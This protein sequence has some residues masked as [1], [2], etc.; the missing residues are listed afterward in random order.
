VRFKFC[1]GLLQ[2][3]EAC[4]FG[5]RSVAGNSRRFLTRCS[6]RHPRG[7]T[8]AAR[9]RPVASKLRSWLDGSILLWT[10]ESGRTLAI[11]AKFSPGRVVAVVAV[12]TGSGPSYENEIEPCCVK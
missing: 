5:R 12:L 6:V 1:L 9:S 4:W 10:L 8:S 11:R 3:A 2:C 7:I